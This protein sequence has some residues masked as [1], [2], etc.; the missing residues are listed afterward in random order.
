M[1]RASEK[2]DSEDLIVRRISRRLDRYL[3]EQERA[4]DSS[5]EHTSTEATAIFSIPKLSA[6]ELAEHNNVVPD[7]KINLPP[8]SDPH[9]IAD[10]V[11]RAVEQ[12]SE[13]VTAPP[14]APKP[15][16]AP[17]AQENKPITPPP[18]PPAAPQA[19]VR[20]S[21]LSV[22]DE[23]KQ[24]VDSRAAADTN[25]KAEL[26]SS[27]KEPS[28]PKAVTEKSSAKQKKSE[29]PASRQPQNHTERTGS[30][31]PPHHQNSIDNEVSKS[32]HQFEAPPKSAAP[33]ELEALLGEKVEQKF[34][35]GVKREFFV[36]F[37]FII[38]CI[39][40]GY[41]LGNSTFTH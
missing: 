24:S 13:T 17:P 26:N 27:Q 32:S 37:L 18:P 38:I 25:Q 19:E 6:H 21:E 8:L 7:S 40:I 15:P 16:P 39:V 2:K 30:S 10:N 20:A 29:P 22:Q 41:F 23:S 4:F 3:N 33:K 11:K 36:A 14:A 9:G 34:V 35:F 1:Q 31:R 5:P 28:I 12:S